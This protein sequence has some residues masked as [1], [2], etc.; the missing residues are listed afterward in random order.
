MIFW[1]NILYIAV[2]SDRYSP[3]GG[4]SYSMK[5]VQKTHLN[6]ADIILEMKNWET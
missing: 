4:G 1:V 3:Q 2:Y 6:R 5:A